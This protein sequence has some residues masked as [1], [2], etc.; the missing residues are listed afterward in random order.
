VDA[1]S[2]LARPSRRALLGVAGLSAA[3]G[4][5]GGCAAGSSANP[6]GG[7]PGV[8]SGRPG[9]SPAAGPDVTHGPR[10]RP[11]VALTFHGDGPVS[12]VRATLG[13]LHAARAQVTVLAIGRWLAGQPEL[14]RMIRDAGHELGNHTWS[15]LTM[16]RLPAATVRDEVDRAAA[17][18]DRLTGGPGRWFRPSGTPRSTPAVR[19]AAVA[20]GYGACLGYDV[21]PLDYTD[22]G[23]EAIVRSLARQLRPGSVVSLHLG[24]A[25]TVAALPAVLAHLHDRGLAPVSA[26]ELLGA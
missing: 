7:S 1:V 3:G 24:H 6:S 4:A 21:D 18:L 23:P 11:A 9:T 14:A 13:A 10:T 12:I 16:P 17:E 15:H 22:P 8:S 25:G 20:A 19:A 2:S 5:L 26:T